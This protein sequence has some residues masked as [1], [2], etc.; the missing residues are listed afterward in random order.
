M[1]VDVEIAKG[2]KEMLAKGGANSGDSG[3]DCGGSF[4][5]WCEW[6]S[7]TRSRLKSCGLNYFNSDDT[8]EKESDR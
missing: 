2:C 3:S 8:E 6:K 1:H 5:I 4:C 7:F